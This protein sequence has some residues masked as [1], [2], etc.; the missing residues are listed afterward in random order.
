MHM[1]SVIGGGFLLLAVFGLFGRL[2]GGDVAGVA[3]G[4][5]VF[6]PVW[7]AV[8]LVNMWIGVAKAGY[9]VLQEL[10]IL[11]VVFAVPAAVAAAAAWQL[12]KV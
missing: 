6:I 12:S 3:A 1:L 8:S 9:T 10:P 4:A 11:F 5:K 7:L 2:W